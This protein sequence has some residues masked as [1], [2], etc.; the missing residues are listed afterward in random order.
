MEH[1]RYYIT[2]T[3]SYLAHHGI[4]GQR[5][6]VMNGPPYPLGRAA[7]NRVVAGK[8]TDTKKVNSDKASTASRS[9]SLI[10]KYASK[11][12]NKEMA[13]VGEAA[14][15]YLAAYAIA[16]AAIKIKVEQDYKND[17]KENVETNVS[18]IQ[19]KIKG[20]HS[21]DDDQKAINPDFA[22]AFD[23][24]A[25]VNCTMCSAAY[26]LR[27]RGYDVVAQKTEKG[28]KPKDA[29]SW[30]GI[31]E[32]KI[33]KY[34]TRRDFIKAIRNEPDGSRGLTFTAVSP[35]NSHHCMIWE[36]ENGKV[37][38]RDAQSNTKYDSIVS[39]IISTNGSGIPYRYF[40]TDNATINWDAIRDAVKEKT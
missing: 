21:P 23:F 16:I 32:K 36:K 10:D 25:R 5:W 39:S 2:Y 4:K 17:I 19:K 14:I 18:N 34:K 38:I 15:A 27:R 31:E 7:H 26:E 1:T 22:D 29:A 8:N 35:F 33:P 6:G 3:E 12:R 37:M 30:F 13:G 28:R 24:G 11:V 9:A 40:R 20:K